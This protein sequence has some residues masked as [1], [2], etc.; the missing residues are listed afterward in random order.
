MCDFKNI[1]ELTEINDEYVDILTNWFY[2]WW[3]KDEN[4]SYE[5]VYIYVRNCISK[6]V[7]PKTICYILDGKLVGVCM[8]S[9]SVVSVRPDIYPWII[10]VYVDEEY[11]G[12]NICKT[13]V[14]YAIEYLKKN[15]FK[16]VYI[17]ALI[18]GLYEK[19]GFKKVEEF[20][21]VDDDFIYD[22]L[23]LEIAQ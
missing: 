16:E 12:K 2:N 10:N 8:V 15:N 13:L 23:R 19:F 9:Y 22:L 3:G 21:T 11:R 20:R 4:W 1:I 5:K 17:H 18:K 7:L 14:T 6:K